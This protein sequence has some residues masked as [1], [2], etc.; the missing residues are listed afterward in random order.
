MKMLERLKCV[1]GKHQYKTVWRG[2]AEAPVTQRVGGA[3]RGGRGSYFPI[4]GRW[5]VD[6][7]LVCRCE[8]V[9]PKGRSLNGM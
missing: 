5:Q 2:F 6:R 1:M 9:I 8:K 7:C 4:P 3:L